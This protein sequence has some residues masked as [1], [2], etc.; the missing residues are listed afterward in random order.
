MECNGRNV[1]RKHHLCLHL[2]SGHV[3]VRYKV[4]FSWSSLVTQWIEDLAL[5]LLWL[6]LLLWDRFD[7]WSRNFYVPKDNK[8]K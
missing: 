5:S 1:Y 8:I 3:S 2:G 7:P 6:W 4:S